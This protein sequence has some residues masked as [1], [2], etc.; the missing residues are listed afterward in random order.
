L[1]LIKDE[2]KRDEIKGRIAENIFSDKP[3][4]IDGP[5]AEGILAQ[6]SNLIK[7]LKK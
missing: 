4:A 2:K 5:D 1:A 3:A 6:V 7:Q